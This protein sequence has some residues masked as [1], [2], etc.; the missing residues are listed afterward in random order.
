MLL[1]KYLIENLDVLG[2]NIM[3]K[4]GFVICSI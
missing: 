2:S 4:G 1:D 3:K